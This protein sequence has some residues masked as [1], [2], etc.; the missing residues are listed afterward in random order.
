MRTKQPQKFVFVEGFLTHQYYGSFHA[1][2]LLVVGAIAIT[3]L[4][5]FRV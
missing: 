3:A 1:L 2:G 5:Y 4:L